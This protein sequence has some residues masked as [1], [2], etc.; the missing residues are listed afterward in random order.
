[1]PQQERRHLLA[2]RAQVQHRRLAPPREVA[3][4]LV[5]PVRHPHRG[6]LAGAQQLRQTDRIASVGLHPIARPLRDQR[7][8]DH[9]TLLPEA[10][11]LP[12]QPI[13]GR[14][15][16]V[17]ERQSLVLGGEL[18]QKLGRRRWR[19]L[20]LAEKAHLA[21]TTAIRNRNRITQL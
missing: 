12:M 9:L 15:R 17:A 8:R 10:R 16:L 14:P 5:M 19:V 3:H 21:R 20:D 13:P 2:L 18:A 4:R 6:E 1:L 7:W 11:D